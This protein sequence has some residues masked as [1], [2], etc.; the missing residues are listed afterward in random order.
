MRFRLRTLMIVLAIGPPVVA[1]GYRTWER[2]G[3]RSGRSVAT[4]LDSAGYHWELNPKGRQYGLRKVR[5]SQS[6]TQRSK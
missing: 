2:G 6:L 1:G 5:D 4:V 3:R